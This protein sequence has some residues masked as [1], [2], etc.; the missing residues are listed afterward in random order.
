M[1]SSLPSRPR[2]YSLVVRTRDVVPKSLE[3]RDELLGPLIARAL[4][5]EHAQKL[6]NQLGGENRYAELARGLTDQPQVL[7]LEPDLE[8]RREVAVDDLPAEILKRPA[9]RGAA[10]QRFVQLDDVETRPSRR[11]RAPRTT[12]AG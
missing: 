11:A 9:V 6:L 12:R 1:A 3:D 4:G 7:L 2:G 10:R 8:R 5:L